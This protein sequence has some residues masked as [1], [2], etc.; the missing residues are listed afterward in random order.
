MGYKRPLKMGLFGVFWGIGNVFTLGRADSYN[1]YRSDTAGGPYD[2]VAS[3]HV[4]SFATY[5]DTTV[6]IG[7]TYFYTVT[8]VSG[9]NESNPSN[10]V[11]VSVSGRSRR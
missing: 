1:I 2:L 6:A 5:L 7:S 9:S 3:N 4:T 11:E 8:A 10:E